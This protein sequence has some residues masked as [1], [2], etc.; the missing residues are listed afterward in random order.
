MHE[1]TEDQASPRIK[2]LS[3]FLENRLGALLG[4]TRVLEAQKLG[5]FPPL[6]ELVEVAP[7]YEAALAAALGDDLSA[8]LDEGAPAR[9]SPLGARPEE[10]TRTLPPGAEPLSR[11]V[12]APAA[13]ARTKSMAMPR[14][15][16]NA[17]GS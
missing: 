15:L 8:A 9:W 1:T 2:Q 13:L 6:I 16:T 7:G 14:C 10:T 5:D 3:I 12:K 4:V 11:F 17:S